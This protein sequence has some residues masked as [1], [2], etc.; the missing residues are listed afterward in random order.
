MGKK[1][2]SGSGIKIRD[3]KSGSYFRELRNYFSVKKLNS[4][5]RIC[6]RKSSDTGSGIII[7]WF[8]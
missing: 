2:G 5:M 4:L 3:E 6:D 1:A 8:S 7:P